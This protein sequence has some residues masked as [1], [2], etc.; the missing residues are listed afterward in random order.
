MAVIGTLCAVLAFAG[1]FGFLIVLSL[2]L[3][4]IKI[5]TPG[6]N[7]KG[8]RPGFDDIKG[9]EVVDTEYKEI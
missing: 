6:K 4:V 7:K 9:T 3:W 1:C 8:P 2:I 5:L